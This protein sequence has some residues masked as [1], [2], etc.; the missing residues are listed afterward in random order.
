MIPP[1]KESNIIQT[2][3]SELAAS[4]VSL[5]YLLFLFMTKLQFGP[6][7][8][9]DISGKHA[10]QSEVSIMTEM[11]LQRCLPGSDHNKPSK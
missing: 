3:K 1:Y 11:P 6:G 8:C 9:A 5:V 4:L 2:S 7:L 10:E